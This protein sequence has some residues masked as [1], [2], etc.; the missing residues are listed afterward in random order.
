MKNNTDKSICFVIPKYVTFSTG[1]AELQVYLL[2]EEFVRRNWSV[3]IV[4]LNNLNKKEL[5]KSRFYNP[6]ISYYFYSKSIIRSLEF[7][8]VF[9]T[10]IRTR[11]NVFYH[12]TDYSITGALAIYCRLKGKKMIYAFAHDDET[13]KSKYVNEFYKIKYKDK[14]KFII[15]RLDFGLVDYMSEWG[16]KNADILL[17]QTYYQRKHVLANFNRE[18]FLVRNSYVFSEKRIY[19]KENVILWVANFRNFKQPE[20]FV[21]LACECYDKKWKFIMI[22]EASEEYEELLTKNDPINFRYMGSLGYYETISWFEKA[23]IFINTSSEEGF[24][25]T[26]IQAW[27]Y[28]CLLLSLNVDPDHLIK[29]EKLGE[30]FNDDFELMKVTLRK[31]MNDIIKSKC[32]IEN[33]SKFVKTEFDI[34]KNVDKIENLI[35]G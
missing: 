34:N 14:L 35:N 9:K 22:G 21:K 16:K 7:F 12:R 3:E 11:S 30:C 15:R 13:R 25:N 6:K 8:K 29:N 19:K 10:L 2:A 33:A 4:T 24:S 32:L 18:S 28:K 26:F 20:L 31:Y 23:K 27:Y 5:E 1:G 17:S